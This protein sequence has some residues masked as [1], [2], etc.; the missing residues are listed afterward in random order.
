MSPPKQ[1]LRRRWSR[2]H[3]YISRPDSPARLASSTST[4]GTQA[5]PVMVFIHGDRGAGDKRMVGNKVRPSR[6]PGTCL[7]ASTILLPRCPT[8]G[9]RG[10]LRTGGLV[11]TQNI[12]HYGG[13]PN[14]I[15]V[16]GHPRAPSCRVDLDGRDLPK[17][18]GCPL[19]AIRGTIVLDGGGHISPKW[20]D[21]SCLPRGVMNA[22]GK[23]AGYGRRRQSRTWRRTSSPTVPAGTRGRARRFP[24]TS[25]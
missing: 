2:G 14:R 7:S 25:G 9:A 19:S 5:N 22:F 24:G 15:F 16:M 12:A 21:G 11:G 4:P 10:G 18:G 8:P 17:A 3:Q 20:S 23:N 1:G 13:D 6:P